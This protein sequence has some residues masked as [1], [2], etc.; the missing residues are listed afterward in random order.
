MIIFLYGPDTYRRF[1][2]E[3]EII[4]NYQKKHG[5]LDFLK[6]DFEEN[7]DD[8]IKVKDFL[9]QPSIFVEKKLVLV[10]E[11]TRINE[12]NW[13]LILKKYLESEKVFILISDKNEPP[14]DFE[15]LLK[16][17]VKSKSFLELEGPKL[18]FFVKEEAKKRNLNFSSEA[19][20]YFL[21]YLQELPERSWAAVNELEKIYLAKLKKPIS[22]FDLKKIIN[23]LPKTKVWH[24]TQKLNFQK[25]PK[26]RLAI[27]EKLFLQKED[28]AYI[29]N[30][31]ALNLKDSLK[32]L[33]LAEEDVAVK[34]YKIDYEEALLDFVLS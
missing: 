18:N 33:K 21:S 1:Q 2:K 32:L 23:W 7:Y 28:P 31:L 11:G 29:F 19:W 20:Y 16:N 30:S 6:V 27:L 12:K 13:L 24:L 9:N 3:K 34:S 10:K 4:E 17:P 14:S 5:H 15:F 22:L 26:K 8:W 25:D